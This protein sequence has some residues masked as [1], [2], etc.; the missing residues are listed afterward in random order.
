MNDRNQNDVV[1]ASMIKAMIGVR[2]KKL[3]ASTDSG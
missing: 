2:Q 1:M 3:N